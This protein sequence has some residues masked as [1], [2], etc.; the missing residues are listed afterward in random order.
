MAQKKNTTK[1]KT[2]TRKASKKT[3]DTNVKANVTL[4]E[5]SQISEQVAEESKTALSVVNGDPAVLTPVSKRDEI[6]EDNPHEF[7]SLVPETI[8]HETQV[9]EL[10]MAKYKA[11]DI[12]PH[13]AKK[14]G[15]KKADFRFNKRKDV[16]GYTWNGME[17]D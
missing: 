15:P 6:D 12:E 11:P 9:D 2:T 1:K 5:I 8:I 4:E 14:I 17:M 16:I 3:L 13:K 10:E 7:S